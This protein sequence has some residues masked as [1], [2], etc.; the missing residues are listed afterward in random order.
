MS[1]ER[2]LI[3]DDERGIRALLAAYC[4]REG[5]VAHTAEDGD[6]AL[7]ALE[8]EAYGLIILDLRMPGQSGLEVLRRARELRPDSEV[9]ILTGYADVASAVE[10]LRLGAYD[11]IEKPVADLAHLGVVIARALERRRMVRHNDELV[12]DLQEANLEIERRR[13]QELDY[14]REIGQ[15]MASALE[16]REIVQ[17][18]VQAVF[19]SI[20]CDV[21]AALLLSSDCGDPWGLAVSHEGMNAAEQA[22]L[23]DALVERL[24]EA[25]RPA[26]R[27]AH[28]E[29][30]RA[31]GDPAPLV[32]AAAEVGPPADTG[33]AA[34]AWARLEHGYLASRDTVDGVILFARQSDGPVDEQDL[35]V[36]GILV[37][38]GS[39]A[40]ENARLFARTHELATRDGLTGLYNHRHFFQ[41]LAG[42]MAHGRLHGEET[43]VI[44][45]DLDAGPEHG[46]KTV[47]DTLGHLAG[48][49]LLREVGSAIQAIVRR[50]DLVARYGGD[51]FAIVAVRTDAGQA[52]ALAMRVAD[53]LRRHVFVV[54]GAEARV[55]ASVG[56]AVADPA[57]DPDA[58]TVVNRADRGLYRAKERGGDMVCFVAIDAPER[59]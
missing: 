38:Q 51:E 37:S 45:A 9:I 47:N 50:D 11:Y 8:S 1:G 48:D 4:A 28:L 33:P 56:V 22:A 31:D 40:I 23:L 42:V 44:M 55:T 12:R 21:A 16:A 46:L 10:A 49:D 7:A 5:Y 34:P 6:R 43:A 29:V 27:G 41:H 36:F 17:V 25:L 15:A 54:Q 59:P 24:P 32:A 3:A 58:S 14:I 18:L 20:R 13:R 19:N 2:V 26:A 35:S 30:Q 39:V 53:E 52:Q 57:R